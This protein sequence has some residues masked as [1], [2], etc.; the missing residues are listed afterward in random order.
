MGAPCA[1]GWAGI[2]TV[3]PHLPKS[4]RADWPP[5]TLFPTSCPPADCTECSHVDERGRLR[6]NATGFQNEAF[7]KHIAD[8]LNASGLQALGYTTA[9]EFRHYDREKHEQV[10]GTN[11]AENYTG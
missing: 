9:G 10:S 2:Q 5:L 7:I 3:S 8:T 1:L 6:E 11:M 4:Q